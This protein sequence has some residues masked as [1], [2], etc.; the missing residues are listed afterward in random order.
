MLLARSE[1]LARR[2]AI[3]LLA[4]R[5]LDS[6]SDVPIEDLARDGPGLCEQV[7]RALASDVDVERL[8]GE[9]APTTREAPAQ[10]VAAI[11]GAHRVGDVVAAIEA[12]RGVVWETILEQLRPRQTGW[13]WPALERSTEPQLVDLADRLAS[14]CAAM[15]ATAAATVSTWRDAQEGGPTA[16]L[17]GHFGGPGARVPSTGESDVAVSSGAVMIVD[18][19]SWASS[20]PEQSSATNVPPTS[21]GGPAGERPLSW[22]ESPPVPPQVPVS[23]IEIRDERRDHGAAA[24]TRSIG[25]QLERFDHDG[26]AFAALLV[27]LVDVHGPR[28]QEPKVKPWLLADAVEDALAVELR[29][30]FGTVTQERPGRYWVLA[31]QTDRTGTEK[32]AEDLARAAQSSMRRRGSSLEVAIGSAVCPDDGREAA[33]LAAHADVGLYAARSAARASAGRTT[34]VDEPA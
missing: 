18:E 14:V 6:M 2:W 25:R 3:S 13:A 32:L 30:V 34:S 23:E 7:I 26:L 31:P 4:G 29:A 21:V 12:L 27:E 33:A 5:P 10:R 1:E 16:G 17:R 19:L 11:A 8:T 20:V 22:D 9:G 28:R 24:W 15:I